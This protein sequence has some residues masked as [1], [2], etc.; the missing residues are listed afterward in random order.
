MIDAQ[1]CLENSYAT[2]CSETKRE[3]DRTG[4][5]YCADIK[6]EKGGNEKKKKKKIILVVL[7]FYNQRLLYLRHYAKSATTVKKLTVE[8]TTISPLIYVS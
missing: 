1:K 4:N 7:L 2:P 3:K 5:I 8:A 6:E